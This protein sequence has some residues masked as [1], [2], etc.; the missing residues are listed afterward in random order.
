MV[1]AMWGRK[2]LLLLPVLGL[3]VTI[4]RSWNG[5]AMSLIS[6]FRA[7]EIL[8]GASLALGAA[9]T[10]PIG[11]GI[12]RVLSR[13]SPLLLLGFL[14]ISCSA[15]TTA[16]YVRPYLAAALVGSSIYQADSRSSGVLRSRR[17]Y[18]IAAIS[19][20]LYVIHPLT[21]AGWFEPANKLLKYARR[22]LGIA[23]TFALAHLS[24][25]YYERWWM[26][27]GKNWARAVELRRV[28][29]SSVSENPDIHNF[30]KIFPD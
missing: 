13:T 12:R 22:P 4:G 25:F 6:Y 9:S 2:G 7:D 23:L 5:I 8:A 17:L 14:L 10:G 27:R 21:T 11:I 24:T 19:Y 16:N 15:F 1:W 28:D 18:Y 20:A 3:A 26:L 30:P 29:H